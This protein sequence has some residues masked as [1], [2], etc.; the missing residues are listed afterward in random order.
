[1]AIYSEAFKESLVKKIL[2]TPHKSIRET[3]EEA[4]IALSTLHGWVSRLK[5]SVKI[6]PEALDLSAKRPLS[7]TTEQRFNA[8]LS[9]T[10]LNLWTPNGIF[11]IITK[12]S[13]NAN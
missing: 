10:N 5:N 11:L 13:Y 7:W 8:L 4:N 12:K 9:T 2:N 3:A 6:D 1:M